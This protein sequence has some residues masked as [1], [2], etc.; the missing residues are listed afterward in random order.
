M[1]INPIHISAWVN[2]NLYIPTKEVQVLGIL[3]N[4]NPDEIRSS[5]AMTA[6]G[7]YVPSLDRNQKHNFL[8]KIQGTRKPH[9]TTH[10][11]KA[12]VSPTHE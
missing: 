11:L 12:T 10:H 4:L 8:A 9:F 5:S 6:Y 3:P 2:G 7:A 1:L